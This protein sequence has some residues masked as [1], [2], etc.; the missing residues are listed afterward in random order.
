M[1]RQRI[2]RLLATPVAVAV[3]AA[4]VGLAPASAA[5]PVPASA[6]ASVST[7]LVGHNADRDGRA[8]FQAVFFFQGDMADSLIRDGILTAAPQ[9]LAA[10]R[11]PEGIQAIDT[12]VA[13]MSTA[14]P[15]FFASFS[16]QLRSGDPFQVEAGLVA[17]IDL[18]TEVAPMGPGGDHS[19]N[20][21]IAVAVVVAVAV[22]AVYS[23]TYGAMVHH[24]VA[25][26][27]RWVFDSGAPIVI[28]GLD[29]ERQVAAITTALATVGRSGTS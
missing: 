15:G 17:G 13:E 22:A 8:L 19:A 28:Q 11:S 4:G 3:A 24:A 27:E 7:S 25:I 23:L 14:D 5:D 1:T 18:L 16:D 29:R 6:S 12:L 2:I 9:A 20:W 21:I 26:N 10:N